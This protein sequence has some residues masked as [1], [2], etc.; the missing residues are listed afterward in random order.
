MDNLFLAKSYPSQIT[1]SQHTN[2]MLKLVDELRQC[3]P[4]ILSDKEWIY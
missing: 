1:L 3:F 2:E 4:E